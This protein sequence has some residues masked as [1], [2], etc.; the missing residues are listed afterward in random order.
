MVWGC[1]CGLD[2]KEFT[3]SAGDPGLISGLG[4]STEEGNSN[5]LQ[6]SCLEN[7]GQMILVGYSPWGR[8]ELDMTEWLH[9][10]FLFFEWS[11]G[12]PYFLH[13]KS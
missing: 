9:V 2:G 3:Y 12:F 7:S 13:F 11:R 4:R 10:H 5:P 8:K 6:Y 1:P